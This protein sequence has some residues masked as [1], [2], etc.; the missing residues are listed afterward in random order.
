MPVRRLKSPEKCNQISVKMQLGRL[1]STAMSIRPKWTIPPK[2]QAYYGIPS[3]ASLQ[4]SFPLLFPTFGAIDRTYGRSKLPYSPLEVQ[5][6]QDPR[7]TVVDRVVELGGGERISYAIWEMNASDKNGKDDAGIAKDEAEPTDLIWCHGINDYGAK[8]L[9]HCL[10]F[11]ELPN[12]RVIIPDLPGHGRSTG[13]HVHLPRLETLG[14]GVWEVLKDV[15]KRDLSLVAGIET[16]KGDGGVVGNGDASRETVRASAGRRRTFVAGQSLGGFVAVDVCMRFGGSTDPS[17]PH[18]AGVRHS[19]PLQ[20]SW[21][22]I[23]VKQGI[24]LCPML[25]IST[26]SRPAYIFE[27]IAK[28]LSYFAGSLPLIHATKGRN[29]ED[30]NCELQFEA[31]CMT[32]RESCFL[33]HSPVPLLISKSRWKAASRYWTWYPHC[34]FISRPIHSPSVHTL[35]GRVGRP[36]P[37][38][39]RA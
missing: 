16:R 11:L 18:I 38:S 8:F 19:S 25:S 2:D 17:L 27:V 6:R 10:P 20:S 26:E 5:L 21:L 14:Q 22:T 9:E 3:P 29:S 4:W 39:T 12:Y 36:S 24:F 30:P 13:I 33:I 31:D 7:Y 32:Y 1:L 15:L 23:L 28:T 35:T 34:A 37:T